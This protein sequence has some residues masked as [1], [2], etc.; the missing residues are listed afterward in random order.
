MLRAWLLQ[1]VQRLTQNQQGRQQPKPMT[2]EEYSSILQMLQSSA[3]SHIE[4]R[5][6]AA[7]GI[8]KDAERTQRLPA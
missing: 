8:N 1:V 7:G 4:A 6:H 2:F 3:E 5:D